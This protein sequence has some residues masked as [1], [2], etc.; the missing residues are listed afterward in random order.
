M[1]EILVFVCFVLFV[2][3]L[4]WW[5]ENEHVQNRQICGHK[6]VDQW[7]SGAGGR[8]LGASVNGH[9]EVCWNSRVV[10]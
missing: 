3:Q 1:G 9:D 6:R 7:W 5:L 10:R 2:L 8:G 4:S